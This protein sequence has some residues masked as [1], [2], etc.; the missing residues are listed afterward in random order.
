AMPRKAIEA[1]EGEVRKL[2]DR[3]DHSRDAGADAA[4]LAGIEQRL[5]ELRD[6]L[7]ALTPAENLVGIA[8]TVQQLSEKVDLITHNVQD[9]T[10]LKQLE[11]AI[12]AMRGIV[13]HVAS[14]DALAR[15][16]DEVRALAGKID[17]AAGTADT[18]ILSAL[19]GRI[20]T[21]ADALEARNQSGRTVPHEI[22]TVVNGL[23]EKIERIGLTRGDQ[24]ALGHLE[25]RIAALVE[26]LDTSDAR[27]NHLEAV[28]RALAE[29]LIH[30]EH[31]RVPNLARAASVPPEVDALSR[32]VAD[33]R[34]TEKRTL[35]TLEVV[36]G[37]LGHVVDRLAMIETDMRS[38]PRHRTEAAAASTAPSLSPAASSVPLPT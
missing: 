3:I 29:L 8:D 14:D 10:A 1:L 26:K 37:T 22:E 19:E 30:L 36:H 34:Q 17:Q 2:A 6:A 24:A 4:A 28:E 27:L 33:L 35:D 5:A 13:S 31:Q 18:G 32:D 16:S 25:D 12:V 20:A 7:R 9:P 21:L 11:G 15:L 38:R 23:I